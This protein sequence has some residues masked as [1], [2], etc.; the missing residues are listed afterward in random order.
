MS[1]VLVGSRTGTPPMDPDHSFRHVP[2]LLEQV[3]ALFADAPAGPVVDA[4][5]GGGGHAAAIAAVRPDATVIGIDRDPEAIAAA[6]ARFAADPDLRGRLQTHRGRFDRVLAEL[7][8]QRPLAGVLFDLGV[9]SPQLDRAARGFSYRTDAPLDMR[10]DP[11]AGTS[12]ATLLERAGEEELA[13]ILG[14][15]GDERH[16][17]R[18]ARAIVAARPVTRTGQLAEIV[19]TAI[20]A[21]A[22]RRGG[23]PA[24]RTF[25][26]LRI[27]VNDELVA[28]DR[29]LRTALERVAPG[30]RI[31]A[32]SYHSG[33]DRIVKHVLRD[34][35]EGDCVCPPGLP[36]VCGARSVAA[37]LARGGVV[38]APTEIE[39]NPRAASARLRA[40]E[41]TR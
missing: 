27:A 18:I 14:D 33:E 23:H 31:V 13:R 2:V 9:S 34:A 36:C 37:D 40:V 20:P 35:V 25:Q 7:S 12:A 29:G 15:F 19:R 21:P 8:T 16:A 26:A 11:D 3:T 22:R 30:G 5:L 39:Q 4:T 32:I 28:L 41:M 10:M 38:P 24:K 17:R 6:R 1:P